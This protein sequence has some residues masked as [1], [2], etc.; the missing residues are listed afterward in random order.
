MGAG[1]SLLC[2]QD[3]QGAGTVGIPQV[4]EEVGGE[5]LL[6]FIP[7]EKGCHS[8]VL[9]GAVMGLASPSEGG[10]FWLLK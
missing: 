8:R 1:G 7:G 10:M 5:W 2:L 4:K 3:S 6:D 9:R